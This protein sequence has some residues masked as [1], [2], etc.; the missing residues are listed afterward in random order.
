[1][2]RPGC[3]LVLQRPANYRIDKCDLYNSP[4]DGCTIKDGENPLIL[5]IYRT[6]ELDVMGQSPPKSGSFSLVS[7]SVPFSLFTIW[8]APSVF[9]IREKDIARFSISFLSFSFPRRF[10]PAPLFG[11][12]IKREAAGSQRATSLKRKETTQFLPFCLMQTLIA[13]G[14]AEQ[15]FRGHENTKLSPTLS[16]P[17]T[18]TQKRERV[19]VP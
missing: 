3:C 9:V 8:P 10:I 14:L 15:V 11:S 16:S 1:M 7:T 4:M 19:A 18:N 6:R 2:K 13:L 5:Y 12:A 17:L